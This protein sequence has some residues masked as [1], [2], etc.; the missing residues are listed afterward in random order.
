[1]FW[2][3]ELTLCALNA[4]ASFLNGKLNKRF[5]IK[6]Y[7]VQSKTNF[8]VYGC[9]DSY[10]KANSYTQGNQAFHIIESTVL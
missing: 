2:I 10:E 5:M 4:G 7:I 8:V 9:F 1:M 3:L 6:V